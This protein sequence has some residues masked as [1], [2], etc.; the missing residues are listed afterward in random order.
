MIYAPETFHVLT[1]LKAREGADPVEAVRAF[2]AAT[3]PGSAGRWIYAGKAVFNVPSRQIEQAEWS[4]VTL[5]QYPSRAD[6]ERERT[7]AAYQASLDRFEAHYEQ[8]ARRPVIRNLLIPQ[9]MLVRRIHAALAGEPSTYPFQPHAALPEQVRR[10][11]EKLRAESELGR[12]AAVVV[13]LQLK[14][15]ERMQAADRRYTRP[16]TALMG[17]RGYGP[18]HVARAETIPGGAKFDQ[19]VIVYYPGTNYF[20]DMIGST[21]YQRILSDKTLADNQSTM[22]A[23]ILNRL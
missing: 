20:A 1:F 12:R 9:L 2:K 14:G 17:R 10:T 19:V 5:V 7:L 13:N 15:D 11:Q 4:A 21:F 8:G 22:T 16:M 23:P 6:F 3:A 18:M